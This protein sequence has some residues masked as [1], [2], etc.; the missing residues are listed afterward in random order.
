MQ[1]KLIRNGHQF[2]V[3][4]PIELVRRLSLDKADSIAIHEVM[5]SKG[6]GVVILKDTEKVEVKDGYA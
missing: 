3:N 6:P 4:I 5:T 1:R 2:K